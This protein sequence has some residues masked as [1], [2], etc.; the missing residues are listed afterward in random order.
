MTAKK[1]SSKINTIEA[2]KAMVM[3][4]GKKNP[5]PMVMA[6]VV[7]IALAAGLGLF[8]FPG[9]N[10]P[11]VISTGSSSGAST[12]EDGLF[13]YPLSLFD[14]GKAR[15][16]QYADAAGNVTVGYFIL[17]STDGV[18]RAAFDACDVCYREKKGYRQNSDS[19]VCNNCGQQFRT[20]LI[21]EVKGGCNPAPLERLMDG[22]QLVIRERDI[23]AGA[24]YFG[25]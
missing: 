20:D 4:T 18:V 6:A 13:T 14:D 9:G 23:L 21:N 11:T 19:M 17:K 22:K 3:N 25:G 15:H 2:K 16:F 24:R 5:L 12:A 8:L 7:I 10:S 1:S